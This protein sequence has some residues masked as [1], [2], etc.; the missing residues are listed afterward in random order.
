MSGT[1]PFSTWP[2]LFAYADAVAVTWPGGPCGIAGQFVDLVGQLA[3]TK[4]VDIGRHFIIEPG[5]AA[6]LELT[7][8][9]LKQDADRLM[10][11][12]CQGTCGLT[13]EANE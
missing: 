8:V 12:D 7:G 13:Q 1:S 11:I 3:V 5:A 4:R 9:G 2:A 6:S 10:L